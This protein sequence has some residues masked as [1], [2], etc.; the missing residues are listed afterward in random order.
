EHQ[1]HAG[2]LRTLADVLR[3][4]GRFEEAESTYH[5][6][7]AIRSR[8]NGPNSRHVGLMRAELG[9]MLAEPGR[10]AAAETELPAGLSIAERSGLP[11][12]DDEFQQVL[13]SIVALY[14]AMDRPADAAPFRARLRTR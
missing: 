8:A 9:A 11:E 3:R 7:I 1:V 14:E 13:R 2:L 6:A 5:R 12:E 4:R 10:H